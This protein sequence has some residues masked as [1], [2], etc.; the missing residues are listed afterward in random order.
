MILSVGDVMLDVLLL[1]QLTAAEQ[2]SGLVVRGGGSAA[3]VAAWVARL[4]QP[5][6]FVGCVGSD[7]VGPM[8]ISQL[9]SA[10][11]VAQVRQ[12]AGQASGCVAVEITHEGER[13]MRSSRGAN[14][15]LSPEDVIATG[16][17]RAIFVHVTA[18]S[19]LGPF[20]FD[21]LFAASKLVRRTGARLSLDPS[22]IGVIERLGVDAFWDAMRGAGVEVLLPNA[23]EAAALSGALE[24][25]D[26]ARLLGREIPLVVVRDGSKGAAVLD[27]GRQS[28]VSTRPIKA[29]DTT[30]AGDAFNAAFLCGL[31]AGM[32]SHEAVELG[33]HLAA[34]VILQYGGRPL[35]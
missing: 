20:G 34:Q 22:S 18:Y 15:A 13:V 19:F 6:S 7:D 10:G 35:T 9:V 17:R 31:A 1:P 30:G 32:A 33:H 2:A 28:Q 16:V 8:L 27:G 23:E 11:V 12:V 4:G 25:Q 29:V 26:A 5:A 24:I 14:Q 3:N 21:I